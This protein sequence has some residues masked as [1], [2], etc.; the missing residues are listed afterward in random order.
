MMIGMKFHRSH[1]QLL[2]SQVSIIPE[3]IKG[4]WTKE[5]RF[6]F[7]WDVIRSIRPSKIIDLFHNQR[8][9]LGNQDGREINNQKIQNIYDA[10]KI[11]NILTC[12]FKYD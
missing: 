4:R 10:L 11:G 5:R 2:S 3:E 6:R 7:V 9:I 8:V 1:I 12:L